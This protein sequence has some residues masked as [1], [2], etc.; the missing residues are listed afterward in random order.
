MPR[1]RLGRALDT[2][3]DQTW[4]AGLPPDSGGLLCARGGAAGE[5]HR[6]RGDRRTRPVDRRL[7]GARQSARAYAPM[8]TCLPSFGRCHAKLASAEGATELRGEVAMADLAAKTSNRAGFAGRVKA[9]PVV[10]AT[11]PI[12][13]DHLARMTLGER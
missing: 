12:D 5:R 10:P 9:P 2:Q 1:P 4:L 3:S 13:L 11:Q 6:R 8:V 7:P